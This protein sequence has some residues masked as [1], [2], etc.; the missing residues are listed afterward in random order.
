LLTQHLGFSRFIS[1]A[2][3]GVK[4]SGSVEV[5]RTKSGDIP[6]WLAWDSRNSNFVLCEAKGSLTANDFHNASGPSC[7]RSGKAQFGRVQTTS[8]GTTIY[9]AQWVAAVRWA[10][11]ERG[12]TPTTVL[13]DPP[14]DGQPFTD[15]EAQVHFEAM[16]R[17]WLNSIA[18]GFGYESADDILS[19]EREKNAVVVVAP[20]GPVPEERHWKDE[21]IHD[22]T[23]TDTIPDVG[24]AE[25]PADEPDI[26][27]SDSPVYEDRSDLLMPLPS[28][29]KPHSAKYLLAVVNRFGIRPIRT[30]AELDSARRDQERAQALKEPAM[31]IGLP[32]K[33]SLEQRLGEKRWVDESGIAE[34]G[35]L[36]LFDLRTTE[37]KAPE[38]GLP[39]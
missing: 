15:G 34:S 25:S 17:A 18:S 20:N 6:D 29:K 2:R 23:L 10:T 24:L 39:S 31:L 22:D 5:K 26:P 3:N 7:V 35:S 8:N 32:S 1:L 13:W 37:M 9:P 21:D 16:T 4:I 28:E 12:G 27:F 11:D 14:S 36:A 33:F 19:A 30:S 38:G